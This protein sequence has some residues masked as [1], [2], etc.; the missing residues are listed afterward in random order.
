MAR[1]SKHPLGGSK[2]AEK[3][4]HRFATLL[5]AFQKQVRTSW[6][7]ESIFSKSDLCALVYSTTHRCRLRSQFML[8]FLSAY[9][10]K[11]REILHSVQQEE[12]TARSSVLQSVNQS[13]RMQENSPDTQ[14]C[15]GIR[16]PHKNGRCPKLED[17]RER[18]RLKQIE[19]SS[20]L[21]A[22]NLSRA[23]R[24]SS[25]TVHGG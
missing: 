23:Q 13:A 14:E 4:P 11:S 8:R 6:T 16:R 18:S 17:T 15:S 9:T 5:H 19:L 2:S 12:C 25:I 10:I 24:K 7:L 1:W 20:I 22:D 21:L 3:K